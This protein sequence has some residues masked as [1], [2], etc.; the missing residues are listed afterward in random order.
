MSFYIVTGAKHAR[1]D[2]LFSS[3]VET[4]LGRLLAGGGGGGGGALIRYE[5]GRVFESGRLLDLLRYSKRRRS[6]IHL[7]GKWSVNITVLQ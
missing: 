5:A 6:N 2:G 1:V 3:L 4:I 7:P